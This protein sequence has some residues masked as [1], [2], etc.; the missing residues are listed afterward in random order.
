MEGRRRGLVPSRAPSAARS[1]RRRALAAGALAGVASRRGARARATTSAP[2]RAARHARPRPTPRRAAA[3]RTPARAPATARRPALA[4]SARSAS[5]SCCASTAPTAPST[6]AASC[7]TARRPGAILF[8]DNIAGAA[9]LRA[10]TARAAPSGRAAGATPI[11]CADQ[12]GGA[13]RNVAWAPPVAAPGGPEPG[14]RRARGRHARCARLGINVALAPVAD[15]PS[16]PRRGDGVARV[17]E[18][19]A[20]AAAR[21]PP[22]SRA[23]RRGRRRADGQA[24]PRPRRHDRQHRPRLGDDRRRRARPRAT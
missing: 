21:S 6:C 17:L 7:A 20:R 22:R 18:R 8:R 11:V 23:G 14:R 12:E 3:R 9:Q 2:P 24:L 10:L 5:S 1:A 16:R 15:V 4:R 19:P 13:I